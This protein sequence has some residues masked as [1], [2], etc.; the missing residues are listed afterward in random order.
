MMSAGVSEILKSVISV[1]DANCHTVLDGIAIRLVFGLTHALDC[2]AVGRNAIFL[3]EETGHGLGTLVGEAEVDGACAGA[4]V[5][6]TGDDYILAGV[7]L[8]VIGHVLDLIHLVAVDS[9]VR[10]GKEDIHTVGLLDRSL[11]DNCLDRFLDGNLDYALDN[12]LDNLG[13]DGFDNTGRLGVLLAESE[14]G[15]NETIEIPVGVA[16]FLRVVR[17]GEDVGLKFN[18]KCE[19]LGDVEVDVYA[20]LADKTRCRA[21]PEKTHGLLMIY[22]LVSLGDVVGTIIVPGDIGADTTKDVHVNQ[23]VGIITAEDV[24]HI[25][26]DV[27]CRSD[28]VPFPTICLLKVDD[29]L[30][31][32]SVD[33][34]SHAHVGIEFVANGQLGVRGGE[35]AESTLTEGLL[36]TYLSLQEPVGSEFVFSDLLLCYG[37]K[38]RHKQ[39]RRE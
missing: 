26:K 21:I 5:S 34:K 24:C 32:P 36:T 37:G 33:G 29:G 27:D 38:R 13:L 14:A 7:C 11:L 8:E 10:D 4:F 23:T 9:C 18:T 15:S 3:T 31:L 20:E 30:A 2:N 17:V 12:A 1:S 6:I 19:M 39:S 28:I 16:G 25:E 22:S 35:F